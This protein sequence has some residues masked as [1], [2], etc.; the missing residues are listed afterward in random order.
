MTE[1]SAHMV[2]E[3]Q[4]GV[5]Q[6]AGRKDWYKRLPKNVTIY[7]S[8]DSLRRSDARA[9]LIIS[10]RVLMTRWKTRYQWCTGPKAW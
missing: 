7:D 2:N 8:I 3:E 9:C 4:I 6:D 5:F 10:D 1:V